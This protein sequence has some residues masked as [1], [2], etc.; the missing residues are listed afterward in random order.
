MR[1]P[2]GWDGKHFSNGEEADW[3]ADFKIEMALLDKNIVAENNA[4]AK[5]L[6]GYVANGFV[7]LGVG[8][9]EIITEGVKPI[10]QQYKHAAKALYAELVK[11]GRRRKD[12][13]IARQCYKG[14]MAIIT[15][16]F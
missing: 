1:Q 11:D 3:L 15:P 2:F 4:M 10:L 5:P 12:F 6:I 8:D 13:I 16:L 7:M 14:F 9:R